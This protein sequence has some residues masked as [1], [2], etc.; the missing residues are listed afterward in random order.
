LKQTPSP[1]T[2]YVNALVVRNQSQ[3]GNPSFSRLRY[4]VHY[5]Q[6]GSRLEPTLLDGEA[7]G[8]WYGNGENGQLY[9]YHYPDV[10]AWA[11]ENSHE[12]PYT[13]QLL[14]STRDGQLTPHHFHQ[15]MQ[16]GSQ[17]WDMGAYRFI[18]H[19]DTAHQHA[20]ALFFSDQRLPKTLF[21]EGQQAMQESLA[22]AVKRQQQEA[23]IEATRQR[24]AQRSRQLGRSR[25][26]DL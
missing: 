1:A 4:F 14:L 15:T 19:E 8:N 17:A 21:L 25:G 10:L 12:H 9:A 20:H 13:Y 26:L 3:N 5:L 11:K 23:A 7:R 18:V 6:Q 22:Q 24:E 16:A 2:S